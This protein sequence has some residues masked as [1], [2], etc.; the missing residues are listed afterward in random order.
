MGFTIKTDPGMRCPRCGGR[1]VMCARGA[2]TSWN[3][4][5]CGIFDQLP[6]PV[7][8]PPPSRFTGPWTM[9]ADELRAAV[10]SCLTCGAEKARTQDGTAW[11]YTCGCIQK[12]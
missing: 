5:V 8:V 10:R 11:L 4:V 9:T 2:T 7:I 1:D 6:A 3:C 12:D